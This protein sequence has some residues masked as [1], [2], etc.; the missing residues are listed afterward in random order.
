MRF[1]P[2]AN[3]VQDEI[4]TSRFVE[5]RLALKLPARLRI[6]ILMFAVCL[7]ALTILVAL[8]RS[9]ALPPDLFADYVDFFP[10]AYWS[11]GLAHTFRCNVDVATGVKYCFLSPPVSLFTDIGL[12][13]VDNQITRTTFS[14]YENTFKVG[15]LAA[16]WGTPEVQIA[17]YIAYLDW[18]NQKIGAIARTDDGRFDYFLLVSTVTFY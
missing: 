16:L 15:D 4:G 17:G 13:I 9:K 3:V 6:V 14:L 5:I 1:M 18:Q 2:G 11:M 7:L 10:G 8:S 12:T